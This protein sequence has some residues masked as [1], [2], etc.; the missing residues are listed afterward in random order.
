MTISERDYKPSL[1]KA[2][3]HKLPEQHPLIQQEETADPCVWAE[4][5]FYLA[6]TGEPIELLSHQKAILRAA[7]VPKN[8]EP[9]PYRIVVYS[10][11][12]KS[13]KTAIAALVVQWMAARLR[14]GEIYCTGNDA[15]Q[16]KT[17]VFK[18]MKDSIETT[19]GYLRGSPGLLPGKWL[20]HKTS[21]ESLE[22][23]TVVKAIAVDYRGEAGA[24]PDLTTWTEL[25]GYEH[26]D[27]ERFYE[28]MM[29]PP[30]KPQ[31]F[32]F[33]ESY[34]GFEG[35]SELLSNVIDLG[36][37]GRQLTAGELAEMS[38]E[39]LGTFEEAPAAED[40]VPI[41]VN[42][43]A[44]LFLYCD[45]GVEARRMAWQTTAYYQESEESMPPVQFARI[46]MNEWVG[47]EGEFIPIELWDACYDP[48]LPPLVSQEGIDDKTPL[49]LALDAASKGDCFGAVAVSRHPQKHSE[50]AIRA[51]A[52]WK[53][54]EFPDHRIDFDVVQTRIEWMIDNHNIV[55]IAYDVHQL[56]QMMQ[57]LRRRARL[58]R[59]P[60]EP[61]KKDVWCEE[62]NQGLARLKADRQLYDVIV[63]R[64]L[65]H[66]GEEDLRQHIRNSKAKYEKD[67]DSRLRIIKKAPAKKIDLAVCASMGVNR[68]LY[69]NL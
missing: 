14:Q 17:R 65:H 13:G 69:L 16:A 32:R 9:F 39:P 7:L 57:L 44:S 25:W 62:F 60:G 40:L 5:H 8:R 2:L 52:L 50:A 10:T 21:V 46:H 20:V 63:K 36:K 68:C 53:P 30:T 1:A 43:A 12:K 67:Q 34:A 64:T 19:P 45:V 61:L 6:D 51:V 42:E 26:E 56:E 59:A 48:S 22:N 35:E 18:A 29:P 54:E 55:Q 58:P 33:I 31:S 47:S 37:A 49:V 15:E 28:E 4:K 23:G 11:I 27:A 24:N 66:S 41:W 38:G 3:L